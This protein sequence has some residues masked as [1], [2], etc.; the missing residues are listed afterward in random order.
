MKAHE[1]DLPF[2]CDVCGERFKWCSGRL[3]HMK[4]KHPSRHQTVRHT[5]IHE[6]CQLLPI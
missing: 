4:A 2:E 6:T 1:K 3:N 5:N